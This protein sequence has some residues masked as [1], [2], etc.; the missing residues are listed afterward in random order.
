MRLE[1][2]RGKGRQLRFEDRSD[3]LRALAG[4]QRADGLKLALAYHGRDRN[5]DY[6]IRQTKLTNFTLS[7]PASPPQS[8]LLQTSYHAL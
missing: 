4:W 7:P 1:E 6:L 5:S 2:R 3:A 8:T